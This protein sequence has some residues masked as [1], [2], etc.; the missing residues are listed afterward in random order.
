MVRDIDVFNEEM[1]AA[2]ARIFAR[3]LQL[4]SHVKSRRKQARRR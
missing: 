2:G 3:G 1:E 4:A